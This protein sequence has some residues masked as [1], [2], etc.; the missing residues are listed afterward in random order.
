MPV[1]AK[2]R[3]IGEWEVCAAVATAAVP[4]VLNQAR[5]LERARSREIEARARETTRE[6]HALGVTQRPTFV[7]E[8]AGGDRVVLSG[9][10]KGAPLFAAAEALLADEAAQFAYAAHH[11]PPP[12]R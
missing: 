4:D 1:C 5:L 3:R 7:L 2:G 10:A 8:N 6:F 9:L 11:G 12:T